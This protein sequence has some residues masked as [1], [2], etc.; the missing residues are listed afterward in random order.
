MR[1]QP[2]VTSA[3]HTPFSV[4]FKITFKDILLFP[5]LLMVSGAA[6]FLFVPLDVNGKSMGGIGAA[7]NNLY[8]VLAWASCYAAVGAATILSTKSVAFK[9]ATVPLV[10]LLLLWMI[11]PTAMSYDPDGNLVKLVFF[12]MTVLTAAVMAC[13][14][15]REEFVKRLIVVAEIAV[16]VTIIG[17]LSGSPKA[18]QYVVEGGVQYTRSF[19][20]FFAHKT[21]MGYFCF[22]AFTIY[23]FLYPQ[24]WPRWRRYIFGVMLLVFLIVSNDITSII[25]GVLVVCTYFIIV[26]SKKDALSTLALSL[27]GLLSVTFIFMFFLEDI[28]RLFGR[29]SS[30][31]GR[32]NIWEYWWMFA[33]DH[34]VFG[35]GYAG[36]FG[37]ASDAP[38]QAL[39]RFFQYYEAPAFHNT[40]LDNTIQGGLVALAITSYLLITLWFR[41]LARGLKIGEPFDKWAAGFMTAYFAICMVGTLILPY[42]QFLTILFFYLTFDSTKLRRSK[43][44][45]GMSTLNIYSHRNSPSARGA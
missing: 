16:V 34:L 43:V 14:Y 25:S 33:K 35:Y 45:G 39:W 26:A 24:D 10:P 44:Q 6:Y 15:T 12:A 38:G 19:R 27:F 40:F 23:L 32:T 18:F 21:N 9:I 8:Y 4:N 41:Y 42:N 28:F 31:T 30:L 7:S 36:F 29:S 5:N 11:L 17:Y 13:S 3:R 22:V 37:Q 2:A 20:G 1:K